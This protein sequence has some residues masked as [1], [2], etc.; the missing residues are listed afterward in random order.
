MFSPFCGC[1]LE[2]RLC[3][4]DFFESLRG[5]FISALLAKRQAGDRLD[6]LRLLKTSQFEK[7]A[8]ECETSP[9]DYLHYRI[10]ILPFVSHFSIEQYIRYGF[11]GLNL[12]VPEYQ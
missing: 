3:V 12:F 6:L 10:S 9:G 5:T 8:P 11:C 7:T 2:N 1:S 4:E